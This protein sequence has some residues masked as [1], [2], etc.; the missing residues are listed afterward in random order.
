ML[1]QTKARTNVSSGSSSPRAQTTHPPQ[2][3]GSQSEY[4]QDQQEP[5]LHL[6]TSQ[7]PLL[8]SAVNNGMYAYSRYKSYSPVI[9]YPAEFLER[10]I[11]NPVADTIGTVGRRTGVEGGLRWALKGSSKKQKSLN[12]PGSPPNKDEMEIE[13]HRVARRERTGSQASENLPAYDEGGRSPPYQADAQRD[14]GGQLVSQT[15]QDQ[16]PPGWQ[17]RLMVSTSGLGVAMSEQSRRNLKYCLTWLKWA[18]Q[19]LSGVIDAVVNIL[20][21]WEERSDTGNENNNAALAAR[22]QAL[23]RDVAETVKRVVVEVS[24]YA[25]G[26]LP[27]NA[28]D[29]VHGY[30]ESLPLR[31]RYATTMAD[32]NAEKQDENGTVSNGQRVLALAQEGLKSLQQVTGVVNDTLISAEN[33]CERLGRKNE[34]VIQQNGVHVDVKMEDSM[35]RWDQK[36]QFS[37]PPKQ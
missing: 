26:A 9:R 12:D 1:Y 33:W 24:N 37:H 30:F 32:T 35:A 20:K 25:G 19:R 21:E 36:E 13:T 14:E 23:S 5:L 7:V 31:W 17:T 27:A 29:L 15:R 8:S 34:N 10:N 16:P 28:R 4:S 22:I 18:N 3:I 2:W 11:G 6:L